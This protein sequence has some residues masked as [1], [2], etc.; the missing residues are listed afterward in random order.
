[1]LLEIKGA[2]AED[3]GFYAVAF[4]GINDN[5]TKDEGLK[6]AEAVIEDIFVALSIRLEYGTPEF[7]HA[8]MIEAKERRGD[9]EER[10]QNQNELPVLYSLE[11][12]QEAT[13]V[14]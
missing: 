6:V 7:D 9:K 2:S 8:K 13:N 12:P 11:M 10:Y 1:M 14:I 5:M 3:D 4:G